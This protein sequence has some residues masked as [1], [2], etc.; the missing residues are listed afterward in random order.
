MG[1]AAAGCPSAPCG[2]RAGGNNALLTLTAVRPLA[3]CTLHVL[4]HAC[5]RQLVRNACSQ[6]KDPQDVG[7]HRKENRCLLVAKLTDAVGVCGIHCKEL[8]GGHERF[9]PC[10][11]CLLQAMLEM[12]LSR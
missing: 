11:F 5:K 3:I 2:S 6:A 8:V 9:S 7:V 12:T 10:G 4:M 1:K